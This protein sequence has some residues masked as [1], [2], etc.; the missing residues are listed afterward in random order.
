MIYTDLYSL[1]GAIR[2]LRNDPSAD[3]DF[4]ELYRLVVI[5]FEQGEDALVNAQI[6]SHSD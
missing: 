1:L 5:C 2:G 6:Q 4:N 3:E